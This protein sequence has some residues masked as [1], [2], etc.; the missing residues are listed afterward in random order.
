[1]LTEVTTENQYNDALAYIETFIQ[2]GTAALSAE[3][4]QELLRI[5]LLVE[6]YEEK[7]YPM[8][9]PPQSLVGMIQVKMFERRMRQ[10]ELATLLDVSETTLSEVLNGKRKINLDLAKKLY[11]KLGI[12]S[13][14]IL[15]SA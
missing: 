9:L 1:M 14:F 4:D 12:S 8:P 7:V 13:D 5:S 2:K 15:E 10:K 11:K 3:E 6:A